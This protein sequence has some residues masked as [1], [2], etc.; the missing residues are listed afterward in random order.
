MNIKPQALSLAVSV[1]SL[2][3]SNILATPSVAKAEAP[4]LPVSTQIIAQQSASSNLS[5]EG[6]WE[7]QSKYR[8][9]ISQDNGVYNGKIIWIAADKETKDINNPDQNL[10]SRNLIGVE[11]LK[12]FTYNPK[13]KEWN[14]GSIYVPDAGRKL[15]AR[16][17]MKNKNE[18]QAKVSMGLFS[19]TL[20]LKAVQA[21]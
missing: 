4:K 7:A 15:N 9:Q 8:I 18:L 3:Y 11:M 10:R 1:I 14:G 20:T 13:T 17:S 2:L 5:I 21:Q 12:G 16:L 19:R 6:I